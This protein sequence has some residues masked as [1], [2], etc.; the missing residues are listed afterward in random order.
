MCVYL[1]TCAPNHQAR[2][3]A[4]GSNVWV[5][6]LAGSDVAEA[7]G[8]Q[9]KTLGLYDRAEWEEENVALFPFTSKLLSEGGEG[10]CGAPL[11]EALFAK[12]PAGSS[13]KPHSDM[14]NFVL[15]AHLGRCVQLD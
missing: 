3:E 11:V 2:L 4:E 13:I 14:S 12:M 5:G 15:T 8:S 10:A 6:P 9:W 7:Y 1:F